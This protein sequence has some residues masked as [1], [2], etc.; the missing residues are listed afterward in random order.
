[1]KLAEAENAALDHANSAMA[2]ASQQEYQQACA[3]G[4]KCRIHEETKI[5]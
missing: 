4:F 5:A 3:E 2:A 1:M